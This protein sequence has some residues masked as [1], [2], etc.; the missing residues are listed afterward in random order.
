LWPVLK[1][2]TNLWLS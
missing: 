1:R 2:F